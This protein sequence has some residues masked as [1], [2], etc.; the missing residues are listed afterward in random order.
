MGRG[1]GVG[2]CDDTN[3]Q[4]AVTHFLLR[5]DK[6]VKKTDPFKLDGVI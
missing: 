1:V 5:G 3:R 2:R 6:K 4:C